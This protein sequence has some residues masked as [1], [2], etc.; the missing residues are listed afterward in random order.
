MAA[1]Q[2]LD[3]LAQQRFGKRVI[4]LAV[5]WVLDQGIAIPVSCSLSTR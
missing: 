4:H 5:S 3:R 1:V 2:K